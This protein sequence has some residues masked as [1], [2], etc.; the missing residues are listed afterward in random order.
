MGMVL[1]YHLT[2]IGVVA[3]R[4]NPNGWRL[5]MRKIRI[6]EHTSLDTLDPRELANSKNPDINNEKYFDAHRYKAGQG[7][8]IP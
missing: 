8:S 4:S 2:L 5:K 1:L 7:L 6:M 3:D